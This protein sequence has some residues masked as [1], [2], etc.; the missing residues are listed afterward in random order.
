MAL[1]DLPVAVLNPRWV[2]A[3]A[4]AT[5]QLAKTDTLDALVLAR[6][7]AALDPSPNVLP[8]ADRAVL[9]AVMARRQQLQ[10]M[11]VSEKQRRHTAAAVVREELDD[12][13]RYREARLAERDQELDAHIRASPVWPERSERLPSVPGVGPGLARMLIAELPELGQLTHKAI[14]A[15][16]GV[17]PLA[18]EGGQHRGQRRIGGGRAPVRRVRSMAALTASQCNPVIRAQA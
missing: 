4:R 14:A 13:I 9:Q 5:G 7:A 18:A 3:F 11:L 8:D 12:H 6:F 15:L 10:A 2:R 1:V 16:V 17:A